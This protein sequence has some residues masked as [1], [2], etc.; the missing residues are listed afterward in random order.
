MRCSEPLRASRHLLPPPPFRPPCTCRAPSA[1][2]ELGVVRR[3]H[4][5]AYFY[6]ISPR[7]AFRIRPKLGWR[8]VFLE[9]AGISDRDK[10]CKED[11]SKYGTV[12]SPNGRLSSQRTQMEGQLGTTRTKG[13][14]GLHF[15]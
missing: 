14:R 6:S 9:S 12:G 7:P 3:S 4:C 15:G 8:P 1:V 10:F 5:Y 11:D 13:S 2:A